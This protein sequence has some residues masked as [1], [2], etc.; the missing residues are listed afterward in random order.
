MRRQILAPIA[1]GVLLALAGTAQAATKTAN[2]TVSASVAKNCIIS[3]AN[4]NLG[5]FEGDNNLTATSNIL[6][7]CTNLTGYSLALSAGSGAFANRT[8]VNGP[9]SLIYNLYTDGTYGTVWGD[10]SGATQV[11]PGTGA[12]MAL[13][14]QQTHVV[15]GRL[16]ASA[17]DNPVGPGGY[18]DNIVATITY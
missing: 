12:G 3:A 9:D 13:A 5:S 7:R 11:V 18:S 2:F 4:M 1:A 8:L 17:N 14:Q 15:H 10:G 16:L 6:V